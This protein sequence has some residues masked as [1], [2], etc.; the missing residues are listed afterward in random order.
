MTLW[1]RMIY[2]VM[3]T[4]RENEKKDRRGPRERQKIFVPYR[5]SMAWIR[6]MKKRFLYNRIINILFVKKIHYLSNGNLWFRVRNSGHSSGSATLGHV[7]SQPRTLD[8]HMPASSLAFVLPER[9]HDLLSGLY[10]PLPESAVSSLQTSA[11][12]MLISGIYRSNLGRSAHV[13]LPTISYVRRFS[14]FNACPSAITDESARTT[15]SYFHN[16]VT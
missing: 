12:E 15:E 8:E 13:L 16:S 3:L 14:Y 9:L 6:T 11:R 1:K 2:R 5:L 10:H 7:R 4:V